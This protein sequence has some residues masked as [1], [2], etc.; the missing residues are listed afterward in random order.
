[1]PH[2]QPRAGRTKWSSWDHEGQPAA[3]CP[4]YHL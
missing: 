4:F 3:G 1:M 2:L